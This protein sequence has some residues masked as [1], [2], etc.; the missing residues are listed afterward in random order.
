MYPNVCYVW[1]MLFST[2]IF[3]CVVWILEATGL[4]LGTHAFHHK[5]KIASFPTK[6]EVLQKHMKQEG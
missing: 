3:A 2:W 6:P 1:E 5:Q 4:V